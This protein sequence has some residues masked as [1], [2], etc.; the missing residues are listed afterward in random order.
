MS[1]R[2]SRSETSTLRSP[3]TSRRSAPLRNANECA[4][5]TGRK[6]QCSTIQVDFQLPRRFDLAYIGEDGRQHR[7]FMLHRALLGSLERFFGL[8]IEHYGGAF[9]VWL[10]PIQATVLPIAD[11]HN[12]YAAAVYEQLKAAGIRVASEFQ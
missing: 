8:L 6:W 2:S 10:A 1:I 3:S 7:P 12:D 11:R 5:P 4:P 9:P